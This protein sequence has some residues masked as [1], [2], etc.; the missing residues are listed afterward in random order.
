MAVK[1]IRSSL[2]PE[3][4]FS[5][6]ISSDTDTVGA[7]IDTAQFD[8]GLVFNFMALNFSDGVYTPKIEEDDDVGFSSPSEIEAGRLIGSIAGVTLSAL[9]AQGSELGSIG[10]FGN[11]RFIR[12]TITSTGTSTGSD[13]VA[14]INKK[15]EVS[16]AV[17]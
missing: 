8:L 2:L 11:K 12:I 7:V 16:P 10:V 15:A 14:T 17:T 1:D 6:T 4:A 9:S 5:A 13:V 3:L